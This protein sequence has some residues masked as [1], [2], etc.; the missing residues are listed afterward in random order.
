M[1]D[2]VAVLRHAIDGLNDNKLA[3]RQRIYERARL[4]VAT[5]LELVGPP[6]VAVVERHKRVL[7]DAIAEV[8]RAYGEEPTE[9][10]AEPLSIS[11]YSHK[12]PP[13]RK[14]TLRGIRHTKFGE[15][16]E[17]VNECL[18][19]TA[20]ASQKW[21]TWSLPLLA[22]TLRWTRVQWGSSKPDAAGWARASLRFKLWHLLILMGGVSVM[23]PLVVV[24][25]APIFLGPICA[26]NAV[27]S[28][29]LV[30]K[31]RRLEE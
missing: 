11:D 6:P 17:H 26:F 16:G 27:V 18:R 20:L 21:R 1:A 28:I 12:A 15:F 29:V 19:I 3:I 22:E 5:R 23:A 30:V 31:A 24:P 9:P 2:F 10:V 25:R 13:R 4:T 7:E 8:E 14:A